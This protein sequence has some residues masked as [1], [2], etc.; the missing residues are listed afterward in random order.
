MKLGAHHDGLGLLDGDL[1]RHEAG[2]R[3]GDLAVGLSDAIGSGGGGLPG[4]EVCTGISYVTTGCRRWWQDAQVGVLL[5]RGG[6]RRRRLGALGG[7][8]GH[9]RCVR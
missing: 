4:A 5:G 8:L 2:K 1:A 3:V 6:A 7:R 9:G